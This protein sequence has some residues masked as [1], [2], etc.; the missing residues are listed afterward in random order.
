MIQ[1]VCLYSSTRY[2]MQNLISKSWHLEEWSCCSDSLIYVNEFIIL[3]WPFHTRSDTLSTLDHRI[4]LSQWCPR[5][6]KQ[7]FD[8][9]H[10]LMINDY[11]RI[12][13]LIWNGLRTTAGQNTNVSL[14]YRCVAMTGSPRKFRRLHPR[15]PKRPANAEQQY[16]PPCLEMMTSVCAFSF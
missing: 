14:K 3:C 5:W 1:N 12:E 4:D 15:D 11:F 6:K 7:T 9:I 16:S 8:V 10:K 2:H 13:T